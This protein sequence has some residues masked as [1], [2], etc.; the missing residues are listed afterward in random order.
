MQIAVDKNTIEKYNFFLGQ[1]PN[2]KSKDYVLLKIEKLDYQAV[3][4]SK[5]KNFSVFLEKYPNSIFKTEIETK[6]EYQ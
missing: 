4:E 2:S 3:K 5:S 6:F 1:H